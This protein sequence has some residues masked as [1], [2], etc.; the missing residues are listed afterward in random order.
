MSSNKLNLVVD[1]TGQGQLGG[2]LKNI[3]G[4][5]KKGSGALRDMKREASKLDRELTDVRKEMAAASGNVTHLV[6]RERELEAAMAKANRAIEGQQKGLRR[7]A[8]AEAVMRKGESY[9]SKGRDN[10]FQGAAMLAPLVYA[11]K[12]AMDFDKQLALIAQKGDLTEKQTKRVGKAFLQAARDAKQLPEVIIEGADFLTGKGLKIDVVT[13]M[14]PAIG[15]FGTAWDANVV[16]ASK[17]AYANFLSLKV[18][19]QDTARGLEIMA[20][21][22][23]KGGFE[24]KDMAEHFPKLTSQMAAF[25]SKGLMVVGDVSAALQVLEG[26]TGDGAAAATN[27]DNM[28]RFVGTEQGIKKFKKYGIDIQKSLKDAVKN[29]RS[30]LEEIAKL[31]NKATGGDNSKIALIFSDAQAAAGARALIQDIDKYTEIRKA[32][33]ESRGMTN[34]EFLRMSAT[35]SQNWE[36]M[37]GAMAGTAATLG[38]HLLPLITQGF[39]ATT[40]FVTSVG[41]WA[42]ANP[43]AAKTLLMVVGGLAG[44]KI[45]LGASQFLFGSFLTS[46]AKLFKFFSATN[47]AGVSRAAR[48]FGVLRTAVIFLAKGVMRAGIMMM[49][50]PLVAAI[51]LIGVVLAGLGYLV[52]KHWDTIKAGFWTAIDWMKALPE[53]FRSYGSAMIA[54]LVNGI[55]SAPGRVWNALKSVV[56]GG[57]NGIKNFLGIKSPSRLFM[58]LGGHMTDGMA[59]GLDKGGRRPIESLKRVGRQMAVAGSMAALAPVTTAAAT[60]SGPGGGQGAGRAGDEYHFHIKQLPGEDA[61]A[62]AERIMELIKRKKGISGRSDYEDDF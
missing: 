53:K 2:F 55:T 56:M 22:G 28:M 11:G 5:G 31:T 37:K 24:V 62:L 23:M 14:M 26:K 8:Q 30:P 20:V 18:P 38:T 49:A 36:A 43:K 27:L 52:Y 15:K 7:I 40:K 9:K 16:D 47:L 25:G 32:A 50:N 17:A 45:A 46:G 60:A 1:F 61:E 34:K 57:I 48:L 33:M 12:A 51:V 10:V 39:Q 42:D 44:F 41:E 35:S 3:I 6:Q 4:L 59:I 19:I 13:K 21:A 54:G 58:Q 29:G